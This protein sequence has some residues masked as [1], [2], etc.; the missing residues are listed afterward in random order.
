MLLI[1]AMLG[2]SAYPQRIEL[3]E[4]PPIKPDSEPVEIRPGF[5]SPVSVDAP[6]NIPDYTKYEPYN[7][8]P[9]ELDLWNLEGQRFFRSPAV[10]APDKSAFAY[11]EVTYLPDS[12]QTISRLYLVPAEPLP[13]PELEHLPSEAALQPSVPLTPPTFYLDR[14]NP[15]KTIKQR[16]SLLSVGFDR[17]K[18]FEFRTLTIVDWSASGKRLLFKQRSGVMHVGLRTSDILVYDQDKGTVTIYPEMHRIIETYW[19]DTGNLPHI[20]DLAWDI[21]P[22]GWESDSDASILMKAW[23]Y[24]TQ[25]KKFLGLWQYDMDANRARLVSLEDNPPAVA[26]NGWLATPVPPPRPQ[27]KKSLFGKKGI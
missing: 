13:I 17:V 21:Q 18:P 5:H 20:R 23:A 6:A 22:I 10:I 1:L 25:E 27:K 4:P 8:F 19:Q 24:D 26:A 9:R 15:D 16:K 2:G 12:R 14:F 3:S 11:T 7:T